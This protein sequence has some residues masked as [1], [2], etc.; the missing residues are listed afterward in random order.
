[1]LPSFKTILYSTDL[2]ENTRPAFR[3]AVSL[4]RRFQAKVHILHII[5]DFDAVH[6]GY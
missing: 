1:M 3:H 2:S 5:P 6:Q 4:A